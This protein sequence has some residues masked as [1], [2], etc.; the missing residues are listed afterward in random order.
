[1]ECR[2][3]LNAQQNLLDIGGGEGIQTNVAPV[4][5]KHFRFCFSVS[6][7]MIDL[8]DMHG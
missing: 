7:S 5:Y 8:N 6:L 1:M 4:L 2:L 3:C